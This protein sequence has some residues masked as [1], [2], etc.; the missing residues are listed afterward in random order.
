MELTPPEPP[1]PT[2]LRFPAFLRMKRPEEFQRV[3]D[4][5]RSVSDGRLIVYVC[6]NGL[7][8][9]RLGVSV[10]RRVGGAVVRNRYKRLFREAF[11]LCRAELPVGID[12]IMIPRPLKNP[13]G[14]AE[15][16]ESLRTLARRGA[17]RLLPPKPEV[18][19]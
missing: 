17:G 1:V 11:R 4:R 19:S 13:P 5:T 3:Y 6:E 16:Q 14:L 8:Y 18:P 12:L 2:G 7:P 15:L 9:P 10:S